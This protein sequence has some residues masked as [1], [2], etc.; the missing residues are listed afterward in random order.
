MKR[1]DYFDDF[2]DIDEELTSLSYEYGDR[3]SLP[4]YIRDMRT[5]GYDYYCGS[6]D[7]DWN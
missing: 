5:D 2:N 3:Y 7:D 1:N 6:Y 4:S